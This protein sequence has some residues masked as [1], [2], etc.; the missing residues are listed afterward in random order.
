MGYTKRD[1][2]SVSQSSVCN[3]PVMLICSKDYK[4]SFYIG[5]KKEQLFTLLGKPAVL[6]SPNGAME[7]NMFGATD[8]NKKSCT[9]SIIYFNHPKQ[10]TAKIEIYYPNP[11][12]TSDAYY[13]ML[14]NDK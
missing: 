2:K 14:V 3:I 9:I 8:F 10:Y 11:T 7:I 5:T 4:C 1:Y 13:Y 6:K 12:L